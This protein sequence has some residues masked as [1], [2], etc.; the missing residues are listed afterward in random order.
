M[1][2]IDDPR[3]HALD[4]AK[5]SKCRIKMGAIVV[6]HGKILG[7]SC[8]YALDDRGIHAEIAAVHNAFQRGLTRKDL[9]G[10]RIV[11]AGF[12]ESGNFVRTAKPCVELNK[13]T[14]KPGQIP[15]MEYLRRHGI[16]EVEFVTKKGKWKVG[17]IQ[18][19]V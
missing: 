12:V 9:W 6:K 17:P 19:A 16:K 11:V 8:N 3:K 13:R 2:T 14:R 15:C 5:L 4:L 7:E 10:A 18:Q 1:S